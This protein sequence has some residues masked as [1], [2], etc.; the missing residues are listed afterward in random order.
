[1]FVSY[2]HADVD[3]KRR[4]EVMLK[5][6]VAARRLRLWSDERIGVGEQW[7]PEIA[8]AIDRATAAL[9]LVTPSFVAS[10]YILGQE[11][12]ALVERSVPRAAVVVLDCYWSYVSLLEERQFAIDPKRPI[13]DA[14]NPERDIRRVC[15]RLLA[16]LPVAEP[17]LAE[18]QR[19][20]RP[21][22]PAS[23][24]EPLVAGARRGELSGVPALPPAFVTREEL[25]GL[26]EAL[27]GGGDGA[28]TVTGAAVGFQG[29]GGIGKTVLATAVAR[30][31]TVRRGFPDGI[32]WV[33]LGDETDPLA[34]QIELLERLRVAQPELRSSW[35]ALTRL[36]EALHDRACLLVVDDVWSAAAAEAF[37]AAGPRGRVLYTTRDAT[38]LERVGARIERIDVL[39]RDAARSLLGSLA[40]V[41]TLPAQA[42]PIL[43]AT[44]R[45]A[46]AV[47]LVGAAIGNGGTTW[48]QAVQELGRGR[49]TFLDHPY[50]DTFK[51]MQVALAG[52]A[53]SDRRAYLTLAVYPQD[54]IIPIPA[55]ARLWSHLYD[56]DQT[57]V[58]ARLGRLASRK[59]LS[60]QPGAITFH[61]LQRE[62]L[63]LQAEN[64]SLLHADLLGAYHTLLREDND[65]WSGLPQDEPYIFEH[66]IYHLRGA[67]D[68]P[69]ITALV[70]DLAYLAR[71]CFRDGPYAAESDLRQ[72]AALA[73]DHPGSPGCCAFSRNGATSSP[74]SRRLPTS[75]PR[76]QATH[77]AP[78]LRSTPIG[79][80]RSFRLGSW[81]PCGACQTPRPRSR[82][83]SMA[84]PA[85]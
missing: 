28:V 84:T 2:A 21:S 30:D 68:G 67:G 58:E 34:A 40:H 25:P 65:A 8:Q 27:L 9:L 81:H 56:A 1:V 69:A 83:C 45:V 55:V 80:T 72:A 77:T 62:F 51:A 35:E 49:E 3:W 66:L 71:R 24:A 60:L 16:L 53:D 78:R 74:G 70:C 79:S 73:P 46:L 39:D 76:S 12:A 23:V 14:G 29:Q 17:V 22:T 42:E 10:D 59:L 64:L 31:D 33:T 32:F 50:A 19:R 5:P 7:R 18:D 4:F 41:E 54:T 48:Q 52:L 57:Q 75:P 6:V 38:V 15:D 43:D 37:A 85:R 61:D 36:R 13:A 20:R 47:A 82:A 44:G 26:R 63:L 11:L